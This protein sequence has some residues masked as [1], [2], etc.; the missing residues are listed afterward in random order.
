MINVIKS[1]KTEITVISLIVLGKKSLNG[2]VPL[3]PALLLARSACGA[4]D[5][6]AWPRAFH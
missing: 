5:A 2:I 3:S 6:F 1:A 4:A